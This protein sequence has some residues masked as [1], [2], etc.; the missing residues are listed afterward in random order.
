LRSLRFD[1]AEF[2][3]NGL[4]AMLDPVKK[5]PLPTPAEKIKTAPHVNK[6]LICYPPNQTSF[7]TKEAAPLIGIKPGT[8]NAWRGKG[9]GPVWRYAGSKV[10]YDKPEIERWNREQT[11]NAVRREEEPQRAVR[12][13]RKMVLA[14]QSSGVRGQDRRHQLGGHS[15]KR[16]GRVIPAG[17]C[18]EGA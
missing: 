13:E 17:R 15:T 7:T 4:N 18:T 10:V 6:P 11:T 9:K 8:L 16:N 1:I 5:E 3:S 14:N 2:I 12:P